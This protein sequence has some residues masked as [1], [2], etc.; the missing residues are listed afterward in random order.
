VIKG[1]FEL[2]P[3]VVAD[4]RDEAACSG[5]PHSVFFP[6]GDDIEQAIASAKE[7][8]GICPVIDDCLEFALETNQKAGVWGGTS[9][10]DRKALRRKWLATRRRVG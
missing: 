2:S 5:L 3:E 10:E 6:V 4:W 8:C 7:I 1:R 9:E